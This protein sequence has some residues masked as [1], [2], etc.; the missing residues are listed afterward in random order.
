M[1]HASRTVAFRGRG[2]KNPHFRLVRRWG[3]FLNHTPERATAA[4]ESSETGSGLRSTGAQRAEGPAPLFQML[5][6][7]GTVF[8]AKRV[9]NPL[10]V[11]VLADGQ[12]RLHQIGADEEVVKARIESRAD[13]IDQLL[14]Q[15]GF[16][17]VSAHL[18]EQVRGNGFRRAQKS[19]VVES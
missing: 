15:P 1:E 9:K 2:V 8:L 16:A 12:V 10:R 14:Q 11:V 18:K 4:S 6:P 17:E 13:P 3:F 19:F 7:I 5:L